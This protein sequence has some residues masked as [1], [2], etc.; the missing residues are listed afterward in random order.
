MKFPTGKMIYPLRFGSQRV[1]FPG[2]AEA[3]VA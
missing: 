3:R 2:A 1:I